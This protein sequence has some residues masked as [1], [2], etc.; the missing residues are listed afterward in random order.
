[1]DAAVARQLNLAPGDLLASPRGPSLTLLDVV[2]S[3][4]ADS[5]AAVS[6]PAPA[7]TRP[8]CYGIVPLPSDWVL[9]AHW[10]AMH[11]SLHAVT[12]AGATVIARLPVMVKADCD[13]Q[14]LAQAVVVCIGAGIAAIEVCVASHALQPYLLAGFPLGITPADPAACPSATL[15]FT[16]VAVVEWCQGG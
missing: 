6:A 16:G 11:Q 2:D 8:F 9:G 7:E 5:L 12:A 14:R 10:P 1:M 15:A 13:L 3:L 4:A